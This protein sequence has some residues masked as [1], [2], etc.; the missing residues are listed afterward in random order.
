[1]DCLDDFEAYDDLL[2]KPLA[3]LGWQTQLVPWKNK[4]VNW[5]TFDVVLIRTPWDYQEDA[6][7]FLKVLETIEAS[8]A[9]LENNIDIVRWNINKKYLRELEQ[10]QVEIVP[11]IW[12]EYFQETELMGYFEQ[13][14]TKQ[15][16]IKPCVSANADNTYWLT[17]ETARQYIDELSKVFSNRDFMVQP[18]MEHILNEGEFSCF[19]FDGHYSHSILKTPKD[20]DFRVQEEH[21][22]RLTQ[23]EPEEK[24]KQQAQHAIAQLVTTPMYARVDFVRHNNSFAMMEAEL[25]EPSLYFNMDENS[26]PL[27]AKLFVQRMQR[28]YKL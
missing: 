9:K 27:F 21:G 28:L 14:K 1:M 19:Y 11:T 15:I 17:K 20:N 13:F 16:V 3:D 7:A 23:V 24:L 22:G 10:K 2:D 25:I 5:S 6:H 8:T 4:N 26:A 18:F 12:E